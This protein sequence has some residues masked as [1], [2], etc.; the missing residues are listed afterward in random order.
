MENILKLLGKPVISIYD[1]TLEGFVKNILVDKKL[2]KIL[3]LEI[4]D[5]ESQDEKMLDAK[6]LYSLNND[7]IMIKNNEK[8]YLSNTIDTNCI[9]PIGYKVYGIDGKYESKISDIIFDDKFDI[10][11]IVMQNNL[12]LSKK[13]ILN[14]GINLII[15]T[16]K[17]VQIKN[18]KPKSKINLD[19][20]NEE[21]VE[22]FDYNN[23][24]TIKSQPN[25]I[26]TA[27]SEFLIG[28]KVGQNVYSETKQLL[29]KKNSR[30]TSQ[31]IDIASQNGKLKELTTYSVI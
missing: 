24:I 6:S 29:I 5:D 10:T 1:G 14:V 22:S 13:Q 3:W 28:R 16:E 18:F 30:I 8:M 31:I 26:L 12:T 20:K 15:M 17:K 11:S 25:K 27:G 23:T 19:I 4:F 7:A 2:K 9:N 21:K